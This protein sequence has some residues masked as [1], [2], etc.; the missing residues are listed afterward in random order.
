MYYALKSEVFPSFFI[1]LLGSID[2]ITTFIGVTYFGAVEFNPLLT[3]IV[4]T[5]MI[6]FL[7]LKISTTFLI[8][9]TYIFAKRTLNKTMDKSTKAYKF[10]SRLM[11]VAFAGLIIFLVVTIINNL[12]VLLA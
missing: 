8:G 11:K 7:A 6:A 9:F 5:S 3:G 4:S 1:V 10:S 12:V 2:C